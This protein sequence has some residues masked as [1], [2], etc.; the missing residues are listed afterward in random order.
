M[1]KGNY[2]VIKKRKRIICN[3]P[4]LSVEKKII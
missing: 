1:K 2:A 3:I 4:N